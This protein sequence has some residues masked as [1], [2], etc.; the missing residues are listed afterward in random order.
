MD[1]LC[2]RVT[3]ILGKEYPDRVLESLVLLKKEDFSFL[4]RDVGMIIVAMCHLLGSDKSQCIQR[5]QQ[6]FQ[7]FKQPSL[8]EVINYVQIGQDNVQRITKPEIFSLNFFKTDDT[9]P[10]RLWR[11]SKNIA[12]RYDK[13]FWSYCY[14]LRDCINDYLNNSF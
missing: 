8:D 11:L 14:E 2:Y 13:T 1:R 9:Y 10:K 4:I 12:L 6:L 5:S 3:W 7:G